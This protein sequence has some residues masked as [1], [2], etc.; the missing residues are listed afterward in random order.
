[1]T[2]PLD[3]H[4]LVELQ[5]SAERVSQLR[6]IVAAHLRHWSLDLHVR[7]VCRA[8]E[9]LLTNVHRHVGGDNE[10]VIELRWTGR[11]L[12]VA[13]ADNGAGMPRLL[14]AGGGLSRVMALSDSWGTCRTDDGKVVWFTR[15]AEVPHATGLLPRTPPDGAPESHPLPPAVLA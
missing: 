12:T 13:V 7:P 8:L 2:V 4:Y 1:M 6:R 5:V 9:E 14:A 15:Y 3:R 10:C 11:H